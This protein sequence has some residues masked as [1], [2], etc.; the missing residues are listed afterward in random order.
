M[1][2]NKDQPAEGYYSGSFGANFPLSSL[3]LFGVNDSNYLN[4]LN[5]VRTMVN[6]CYSKFCQVSLRRAGAPFTG[7]V[8]FCLYD[9]TFY[10]K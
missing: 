2:H 6:K 4:M 8:G 5:Q 7:Q 3:V 10:N 9:G 1:A